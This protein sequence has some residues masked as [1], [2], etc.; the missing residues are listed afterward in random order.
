MSAYCSANVPEFVIQA[1]AMIAFVRS[2]MQPQPA[3]KTRI[4]FVKMEAKQLA[5]VWTLE[6]VPKKRRNCA[7]E[8]MRWPLAARIV[9]PSAAPPL[10]VVSRL[11]LE[12]QKHQPAALN[13]EPVV[14]IHLL[15]L[16]VLTK[17]PFLNRFAILGA[18]STSC[19]VVPQLTPRTLRSR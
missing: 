1:L 11:V 17:A 12:C 5:F 2:A 18:G 14:L 10:V 7:I 4:V 6:S 13:V 15:F 19:L 9:D 16:A 8:F 3:Q